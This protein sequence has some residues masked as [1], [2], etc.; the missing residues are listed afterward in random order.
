MLVKENP[1]RKKAR[2]VLWAYTSG[3]QRFN[4]SPFVYETQDQTLSAV[5]TVSI[6]MFREMFCKIYR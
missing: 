3:S 6:K 4:T 1:D 2:R 5:S